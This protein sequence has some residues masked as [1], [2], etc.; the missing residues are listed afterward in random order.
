M[1]EDPQSDS[2]NGKRK[3]ESLDEE[4]ETE[5]VNTTQEKDPDLDVD[6][7]VENNTRATFK[8]LHKEDRFLSTSFHVRAELQYPPSP[9]VQVFPTLYTTQSRSKKMRILLVRWSYHLQQH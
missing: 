3:R 4:A 5:P 9:E 6:E 8:L 2:W 1:M 7:D